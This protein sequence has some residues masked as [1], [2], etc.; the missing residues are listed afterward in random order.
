MS[1]R[2]LLADDHKITREG[3]VS[4]ISKQSDM[5]VVAEAENGREAVDFVTETSVDMAFIDIHMP[6]M[7]GFELVTVL[8]SKGF[9][10]KVLYLSGYPDN[11]LVRKGLEPEKDTLLPKPF[12][13]QDLLSAVSKLL[14]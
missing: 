14:H 12:S 7:N 3:L 4:L 6:V 8:R 9:E 10:P 13:K 11:Q 5:E 2:I 1:I